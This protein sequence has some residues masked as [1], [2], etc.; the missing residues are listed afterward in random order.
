[1]T[2]ITRGQY[3]FVEMLW[4]LVETS[5]TRINWSKMQRRLLRISTCTVELQKN[6]KEG[7]YP[8]I[9]GILRWLAPPLGEYKINWYAALD[10]IRKLTRVSVIV[11]DHVAGIGYDNNVF[12]RA[13]YH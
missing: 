11:R 5:Y 10:N 8:N 4:Y 7:R 13:I 9:N 2:T 3:G 12:P 1:M 6:P